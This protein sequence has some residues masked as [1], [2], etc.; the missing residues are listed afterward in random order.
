MNG[1][2]ADSDPDGDPI[3]VTLVQTTPNGVLTF[4]ADGSFA[5]TPN[6]GFA[7]VDTFKYRA[8][9]GFQNSILSL[10]NLAT[11]SI[12]VIDRPP[13][14]NSDAYTTHKTLV[15]NTANGVRADDTDPEQVGRA[16]LEAKPSTKA[17]GVTE[18][19]RAN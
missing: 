18:S 17:N 8:L 3:T 14:A 12:T 19:P 2:G 7:G 4:S 11:A 10:T 9:D 1:A 6:V 13:V 15:A 5:Y 16:L